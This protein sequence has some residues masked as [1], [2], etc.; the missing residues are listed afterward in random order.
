[1][2][3]CF[4]ENVMGA[5]PYFYF[6]KYQPDVN[7]ALQELREREFGRPVQSGHGHAVPEHG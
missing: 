4:L 7:K 6:V 3:R 5:V 1:M 2:L